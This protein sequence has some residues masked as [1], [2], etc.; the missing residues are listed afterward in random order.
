MK[1]P[2]MTK[3]HI[4]IYHKQEPLVSLAIPYVYVITTCVSWIF[5]FFCDLKLIALSFS[6]RQRGHYLRSLEVSFI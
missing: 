5:S 1:P 4:L 3:F 2:L 6:F